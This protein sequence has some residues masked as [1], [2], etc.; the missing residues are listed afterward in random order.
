[1]GLKK[2]N[3]LIEAGFDAIDFSFPDVGYEQFTVDDKF[4]TEL[5][6]YAEDKGVCFNQSHAPAPSSLVED[7]KT[8]KMFEVIVST[9]R[10]AACLGVKN[11][12]VH[13]CQHLI[14]VDKGVPEKLF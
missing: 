2:Q 13:P 12:V 9:M 4:Y 6:K 10:R 5:R 11:I 8:K 3:L 14:Y 7:E 1:M